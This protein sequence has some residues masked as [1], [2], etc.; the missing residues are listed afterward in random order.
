MLSLDEAH[1]VIEYEETGRLKK[2]LLKFCCALLSAE[3][4]HLLVRAALQFEIMKEVDENYYM[5][6]AMAEMEEE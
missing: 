1:D 3:E 4:R 2:A 6:P 5:V